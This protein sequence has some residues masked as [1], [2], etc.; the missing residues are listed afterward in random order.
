MTIPPSTMS[1]SRSVWFTRRINSP[2][3]IGL[4]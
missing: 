4:N 2:S 3:G 1:Q